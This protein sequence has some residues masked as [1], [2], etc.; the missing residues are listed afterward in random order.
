MKTNA[1]QTL[2]STARTVLSYTTAMH[3]F[4][5]QI[6]FGWKVKRN[7]F[8]IRMMVSTSLP[9]MHNNLCTSCCFLSHDCH[10]SNVALWLI[11]KEW[12][13]IMFPQKFCPAILFVNKYDPLMGFFSVWVSLLLHMC[14]LCINSDTDECSVSIQGNSGPIVLHKCLALATCIRSKSNW[15]WLLFTEFA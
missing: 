15:V 8:T 11:A 2:K 4:T 13:E 6:V 9:M 12:L 3:A 10:V 5:K 1:W 7:V 14:V